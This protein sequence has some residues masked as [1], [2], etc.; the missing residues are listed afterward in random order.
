LAFFDDW[1]SDD[2]IFVSNF[3]LDIHFTSSNALHLPT[4]TG[5]FKDFTNIP[6]TMDMFLNRDDLPTFLNFES[7]LY[8]LQDAD[9]SSLLQSLQIGDLSFQSDDL[10]ILSNIEIKDVFFLNNYSTVPRNKSGDPFF[11]VRG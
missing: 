2:N 9:V 1:I 7:N 5:E 3:L 11:N 6:T 8:D 4:F 10:V